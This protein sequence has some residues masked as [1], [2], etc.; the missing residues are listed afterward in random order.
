MPFGLFYFKIDRIPPILSASLCGGL[1]ILAHFRHF[2]H[3]PEHL[4]RGFVGFVEL[5]VSNGTQGT[6][7]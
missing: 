4:M 2:R 5:I 7:T 1:G 6:E 3:F